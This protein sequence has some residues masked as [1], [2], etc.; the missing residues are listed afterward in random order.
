MLHH[1]TYHKYRYLISGGKDRSILLH[2]CF[3]NDETNA[4]TKSHQHSFA[5][6]AFLKNAHKR[7]I[8]DLT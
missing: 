8:W 6:R 7:I 2:E 3:Q 5:P 1:K 4:T